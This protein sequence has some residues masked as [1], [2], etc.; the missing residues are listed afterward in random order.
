MKHSGH[1]RKSNV[2]NYLI[3]AHGNLTSSEES[4]K[5]NAK[6]G[7]AKKMPSV[8]SEEN[9]FLIKGLGKHPFLLFLLHIKYL[10]VRQPLQ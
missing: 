9:T 1:L 5:Q 3:L 10:L 2:F 6:Y 7:L 4:G 8:F